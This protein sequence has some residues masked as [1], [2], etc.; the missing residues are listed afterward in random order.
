[1]KQ[2]VKGSAMLTAVSIGEIV[3]RFIRTK[4]IA[5]FLGPAGTGF[6]APLMIFFE[7]LRVWGDLGSRRGVIKQIAEQRQSGRENGRYGE[8]I[9]TSYVLAL[10]ASGITGLTATLFSPAIS[11]ALY[12]TPSHYLFVVF[13]A[14]LLPA[15]SISTVTASI[16]K[17]NLDYTSFAKYTFASYLVVMAI[18]PFLIYSMRYWGAVLVQ[19]LFFIVPLISYLIF[20]SRAKFINLSRG[21][22]IAALKEQ[23]SYG[24]VQV[25]QD[26]LVNI[27][28][29]LIAAWVVQGLGLSAMGMY[30]VVITFSTAYMAIPI[31]AMSGYVLPV[32]AAAESSREITRVINESLR[33]QIFTLVP[34]IVGIMVLSEFFIR[35]F[36]S[37]DFLAAVSPLQIQLF[38]TSFLLVAYPFAVALQARGRLKAVFVSATVSPMLYIGLSW[39]LFDFNSL[40]GIAIAFAVSN[41]VTMM[42][43][44]YFIRKYFGFHLFPK[45]KRLLIITA[46]WIGL[47]F[48]A[49]SMP[50]Q[51]RFLALGLIIPWFLLS[52]KRHERQFIRNKV[53]DLK[54]AK[55][56]FSGKP[57]LKIFKS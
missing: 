36:F 27:S 35:L 16:V 55:T 22:N 32:I 11:Q 4:C 5:L 20:N 42:M 48:F 57:F 31:Q 39:L 3:M 23:I 9:K 29:V 18:T 17:G 12:G 34:V 13:T 53:N 44:Y 41:F 47:A 10:V 15:A 45:N 56:L 51:Y 2:L 46:V 40:S 24:T 38:G 50:W 7:M 33:F 1:M 52:S 49:G 54:E 30:Q 19:G 28:K 8:I 6:L 14:L 43:Q 25:Y 37:A 26:S 21:I